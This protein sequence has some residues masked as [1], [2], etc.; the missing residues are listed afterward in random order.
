MRLEKLKFDCNSG[1]TSGHESCLS[2][3]KCVC[4]QKNAMIADQ[5]NAPE[6]P[7]TNVTII[8]KE[9]LVNDKEFENLVKKSRMKQCKNPKCKKEFEAK[10]SWQTFHSLKCR[11]DYHNAINFPSKGKVIAKINIRSKG[12]CKGC[13]QEYLVAYPEVQYCR[14]C[15]TIIC[16]KYNES[17]SAASASTNNNIEKITQQI[18]END[19]QAQGKQIANTILAESE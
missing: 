2:L 17:T 6:H 16:D 1:W 10:R 12:I 8:A 19:A 9:M 7:G 18:T 14:N 11:N 4:Q 15:I 13:R 3:P 5:P